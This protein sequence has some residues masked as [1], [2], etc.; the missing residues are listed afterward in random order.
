M[1]HAIGV[2]QDKKK[3]QSAHVQLAF[4]LQQ[5]ELRRNSMF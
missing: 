3:Y 1:E 5:L 2:N 4:L